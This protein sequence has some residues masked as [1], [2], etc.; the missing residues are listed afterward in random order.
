[1]AISEELEL[2]ASDLYYMSE[3]DEPFEAFHWQREQGSPRAARVRALAGQGPNVRVDEMELV[4][5]FDALTKQEDWFDEE[6]RLTAERYAR[7]R[8]F[9]EE[10]LPGARVFWVNG[11]EIEIY[12][13]GGTDEGGW[14]GV[15]TK[16][17][18]T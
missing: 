14:A 17:V 6:E 16:A 11:P 1:M 12:I 7:L 3:A 9:I 5:F 18:E 2:A 4:K 15:K 10:R 13:V 8:Q